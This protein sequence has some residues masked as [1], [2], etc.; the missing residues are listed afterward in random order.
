MDYRSKIKRGHDKWVDDVRN[1]MQMKKITYDELAEV[2]GI[3]RQ[4]IWLKLIKKKTPILAVEKE[5]INYYLK[6]E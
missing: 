5:I 3:T 6:G 2:L 1:Q 4:S